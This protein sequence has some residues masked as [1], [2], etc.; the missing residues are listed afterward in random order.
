MLPRLIPI[1]LLGFGLGPASAAEPPYRVDHAAP[2]NATEKPLEE[3]EKF[4]L[5]RVEFNG[6]A[7]D[8][9]PGDLYLPKGKSGRLPAVLVQ[10]GIG[11]KKQS[12]YIVAT[13][14]LL[15]E[16][17]V[18]ALAI[19]APDRGE[20]RVDGKK[21]ASIFDQN[22]V[23]AWFRQH[24]G[25]YSRA[26]DFLATRSEVDPG[27]F[28]YIGFSWGAITGITYAAHDARVKALASIGG[29]GNLVG[30]LG[31]PAAPGAEGKAPPSLDPAHNIGAFAPRPLLLIN[32]K[33]DKVVLAPFAQA[34]HQAAGEGATV[35]WYDTDHYFEG[36]DRGKILQSIVE[37]MKT[38]LNSISREGLGKSRID[39]N[40]PDAAKPQPR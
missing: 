12:E 5:V 32:A 35:V 40:K 13:C 31:L 39:S 3:N 6:I 26:F 24:C 22:A 29:G 30:Y 38:K 16:Q 34:L 23:H 9:V 36:V 20:R 11:D 1:A 8:R 14:R 33:R 19:D 15:G 27:R 2:L 37:F 21:S 10:H 25:D 18:V 7:G 28:G 17:G 4:A